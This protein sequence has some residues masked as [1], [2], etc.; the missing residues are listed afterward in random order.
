MH[1]LVTM[2][3]HL[4]IYLIAI[5]NQKQHGQHEMGIMFE[6]GVVGIKVP[7]I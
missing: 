5:S 7:G 4:Y 1:I 2:V 3:I 6:Y